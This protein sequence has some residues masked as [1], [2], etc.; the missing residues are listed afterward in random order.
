M[1]H[2]Q[3]SFARL[4]CDELSRI[5]PQFTAIGVVIAVALRA[6]LRVD[7][8]GARSSISFRPR[9]SALTAVLVELG[10]R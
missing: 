8:F 5:D 3:S 1:R 7:F 6:V 2:G 4:L 9:S 10:D